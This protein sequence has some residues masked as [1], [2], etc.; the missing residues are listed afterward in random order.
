MDWWRQGVLDEK[1][2]EPEGCVVF[3][4]ERDKVPV[5]AYAKV[6]AKSSPSGHCSWGRAERLETLN[7][8]EDVVIELLKGCS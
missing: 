4:L 2:L 5:Q 1:P 3:T 7:S 8:T 6:P